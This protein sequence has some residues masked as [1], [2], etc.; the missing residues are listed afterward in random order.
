MKN[1]I[2][3]VIFP[4]LK[5]SHVLSDIKKIEAEF[6]KINQNWEA[7]C[8]LDNDL[9]KTRSQ[10]KITRLPH[11]KTLFY[12]VKRFGRGF[13]LCYGFSQ[14][15]GSLVFF[16]EGNFSISPEQLIL[17]LG[18]MKMVN[19]DIVI[20]SKRHPLSYVYYSPLRRVYSKIY[21]LLVKVLFGLN[22]TDTQVGLKLYKRQVLNE[23]IPQIII[24]NWAF[25]LEILV[26][27]HTLGFKRIIEAPVEIKRH[28]TGKE[29][30]FSNISNLLKDTFAIFYRKYLLK[31]YQPQIV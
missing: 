13:A 6:S 28:F 2:I 8:V 9:E 26:V 22:V 4:V 21:Q 19:A 27:A 14:S 20:G 30:N 3:S 17:Y 23:V 11:I 7:V 12:P 15:R 25:D 5:E 10:L 18:L 24:K 16:W 31:Y 29:V 1:R